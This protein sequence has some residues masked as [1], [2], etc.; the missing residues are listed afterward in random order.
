M[1]LFYT[2]DDVNCVS[3]SFMQK[4]CCVAD[5]QR[6]SGTRKS[7]NLFSRAVFEND[8]DSV[9]ESKVAAGQSWR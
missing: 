9:K 4:T 8:T 1:R 6:D 3:S 5:W 2:R 7:A